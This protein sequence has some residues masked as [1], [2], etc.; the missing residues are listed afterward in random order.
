MHSWNP[1]IHNDPKGMSPKQEE[2]A[3]SNSTGYQVTQAHTGT[4]IWACGRTG[5]GST[6]GLAETGTWNWEGSLT[7]LRE[8]PPG[9]HGGLFNLAWTQL[10]HL[11]N[12]PTCQMSRSLFPKWQKR[13]F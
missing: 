5:P 2:G 6:F 12:G 3:I 13:E 8:H 11:L 9:F 7:E 10:A 1:W 4:A